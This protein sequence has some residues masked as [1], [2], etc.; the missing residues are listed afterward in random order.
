M[1]ELFAKRDPQN[2]TPQNSAYKHDQLKINPMW[3]DLGALALH[4]GAL[5][6]TM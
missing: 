6:R 5:E 2:N 1:C 4:D 3:N